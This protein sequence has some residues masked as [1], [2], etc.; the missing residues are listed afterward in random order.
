MLRRTSIVDDT[1]LVQIVDS[2]LADAAR[3]S[4]HWL[5]CRPGCTQ[6]CIGAFTINQLDAQRPR[7]WLARL[8]ESSPAK[9][10]A[11]RARAQATVPRLAADF[12]GVSVSGIFLDGED[13]EQRFS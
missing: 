4:G 6:C 5:A 11:V 9:A 2:A 1:A 10:E 13:A 3:R 7:R 8:E 12:P